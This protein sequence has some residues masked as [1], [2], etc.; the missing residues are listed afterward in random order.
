ML[1]VKLLRAL[2]LIPRQA[3]RVVAGKTAAALFNFQEDSRV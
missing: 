1:N 2:G 3:P